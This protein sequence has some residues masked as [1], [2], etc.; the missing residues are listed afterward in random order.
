MGVVIGG[1]TIS[2]IGGY[3]H[4]NSFPVCLA[5][6]FLGLLISLPIP[7]AKTKILTYALT[8]LLLFVGA[9]LVPTLT[10]IMINSVSESRR[11]TA[12]SLATLGYNLFGY[13]PAPILYGFISSRGDNVVL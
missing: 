13:L 10:G 3:N 5:V 8:W 12:N 2:S 4:K 9:F 6:A 1:V 11:T 7:F